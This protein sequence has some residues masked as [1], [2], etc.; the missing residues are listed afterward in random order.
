[1][2]LIKEG[3][4]EGVSLGTMGLRPGS[5]HETEVKEVLMALGS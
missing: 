3:K 2:M 4:K 1:M 5:E